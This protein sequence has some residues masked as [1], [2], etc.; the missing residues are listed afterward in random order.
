MRFPGVA[1]VLDSSEEG[2]R[3]PLTAAAVVAGIGLAGASAAVTYHSTGST[4]AAIAR[5]LIVAAPVCVG[6]YAWHHRPGERFG[7]LLMLTGFGWFVANFSESEHEV[8]YSI[9]RAAGWV[10][11]VLLVYLVLSF[12]SGRLRERIDRLLVGIAGGV[13]A[14]LY[15]PTALVAS[16]YPAPSPVS[17]CVEHCPG[18]AFSVVGSEPAWLDSTVRPLRETLTVL[19]FAAVLVRLAGRM[20]EAT[21]LMRRTLAPVL[22]VAIAR[23]ALL[24][25]AIATRAIAPGSSATTVLTWLAALAVPA[26]AVSFGIGL[27]RQRLSM[28]GA[29]E[30]VGQRIHDGLPA[31][32]LGPVLAEAL[33]D[34]SLRLIH[35]APARLLRVGS[36][37][38]VTE[39][40]I[41]GKVEAL[42][43]HDASLLRQRDLLDTV[44][45]LVRMALE[46]ERLTGEVATS[47]A[48]VA[49]SRA[50][51]HA[52]ADDERRRIERDLH[53][54]A[55]QRLVAL[56][57]KLALAEE[58]VQVDP[59]KGASRLHALGDELTAT[60]E[61]IR[62]LASGVYPSLLAERGLAEALLAAARRAPTATEVSPDGVGR[63][64][65]EVESAVYFCCLEAL[66]N[67]SKHAPGARH[68]TID[69]R[70]DG[71]LLFDVRD[72]GEGFDVA[73]NGA[74]AGLT[75]MRDRIEAVGGRL[76]VASAPGDGTLVSGSVPLASRPD[77]PALSDGAGRA[78]P[79]PAA[80]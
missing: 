67:A 46:N 56:R 74:G 57:V 70:E 31:K 33:G 73:A 36:G 38:C 78:S 15:L 42:V 39:V 76:T 69:L 5:G 4:A 52:A 58:L 12:P 9:G 43:V 21:P 59:E 26:M 32:K 47:L 65:P 51:I 3:S 63:Y 25:S 77:A 64:P 61:D 48:E 37:R 55:Q 68:V 72:D 13:V 8:L 6:A 23:L 22:V 10:L 44:V 27:L 17:S 34:R 75:N 16:D 29:V 2:P 49:A 35:P 24:L 79:R 30:G 18:N 14:L 28:A 45:T 40:V 41:G 11:E 19:I 80:R 71:R 50:R 66:Q 60:L 62:S 20:R 1:A 54:G 7:L 53:D